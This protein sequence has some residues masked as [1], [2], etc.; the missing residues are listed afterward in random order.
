MII[1]RN[2]N[3]ED[4]EPM[5]EEGSETQM[6]YVIGAVVLVIVIAMGYFLWPK[7]PT[8]SPVQTMISLEPTPTPGP[9]TKFTC[10]KQYYNPVIGLPKYFVSVEGVDLSNTKSVTCTTEINVANK[11]VATDVTQSTMSAVPERNGNIFKCTTK[12]LDLPKNIPTKVDVALK[13][14]VNSTATCSATFLL[15]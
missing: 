12:G 15:P 14:D 7:S 13:D 8:S 10:E 1:L 2:M 9:I 6:Y 4:K 3:D 5:T 11:V